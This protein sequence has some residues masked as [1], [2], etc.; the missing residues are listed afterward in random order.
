MVL[1]PAILLM[2]FFFPGVSLAQ[3]GGT[4]EKAALRDIIK[5]RWEKAEAR[6][7][8]S[9]ARDSLNPSARY[10][11]SLYYFHNDNPAYH[12]D[13]AYRY[14]VTAI[15][16]YLSV[17]AKTRDRLKRSDL[18]STAVATLRV[19]IETAAFEVARS[20][21]TEPAYVSFLRHFPS[22][23]QRQVAE[24]LRNEVAYQTALRENTTDAFRRYFVS[25]PHSKRA[26]DAQ[27]RYDRMLF[28]EATTDRQ[29]ASY[30][31]FL[32]AHP[33]TPYKEEIHKTIFE[34]STARGNAESYLSFI[35]DYPSNQF[36]ERAR[37]IVFYLLAED[38]QPDW[39]EGFLTDSLRNILTL[40]AQGLVP[41]LKDDRF[42][43]MNYQGVEII[44]PTYE[45]IHEDYLCG[46]V[47]DDILIVDNRLVTRDGITICRE[48]VS[49]LTDLGAGFLLVFSGGKTSVLHKSGFIVTDS[50]DD[51]RVINKRFLAVR[52]RDAWWLY[53]LTGRLL[54]ARPW[55]NIDAVHDL[56]LLTQK[57]KKFIGRLGEMSGNIEATALS[58]SDAF[59]EVK[60]W[61][62]GLIWGRSGNFEGVLNDRLESVIRFDR[63]GLNRTSFGATATLQSGFALYNHA[64]KR[65]SIFE[66]VKVLGKRVAVRKNGSWVFFDPLTHTTIGRTYDSLRFE[67]P[68]FLV[69]GDSVTAHFQN[70]SA[71]RFFRPRAI[72]FVPGMDSTSFLVVDANGREK[73]IFDANGN[74]LFA[75]SFDAIEYAGRGIFVISRREKKGLIT[76]KGQRLLPPEF[77]AVGSVQDGIISV[78]KNKKFGTFNI[79]KRKLIQPIYDRNP[80]PYM[81]EI[82]TVFKDGYYGFVGWDGNP[83]SPFEFDEVAPW[84]D[85]V[86]LVRQ[87]SSWS[88]YQ[89]ATGRILETGLRSI[90]VVSDGPNEKV[91]IVQKGNDFGVLSN[92]GKEIIPIT[93]SDIINIGS[94]QSPL[95]FTEKHIPEASLHV[96]IYFDAA[97]N[98][99]RKEMYDDAFNF[100]RI[101]CSDH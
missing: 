49:A 95:Y 7:R 37:Q 34:L 81:Q 5:H 85:S 76:D 60:P 25:Y 84:S 98:M 24:E 31:A 33:E 86:A 62:N 27:M 19:R 74:K 20:E 11:L 12:L 21:N 83:L 67:G 17:S 89:I 77:D 80:V 16:D 44:P 50:V 59:D 2:I 69:V 94:R 38:D 71:R 51:A 22:A 47:N 52:E 79:E 8:K 70:G 91:A 92:T 40:N 3:A 26:G 14:A 57:D 46:N 42:G 64:G 53:T 65:S 41:F 30:E 28:E 10:A 23:M 97:G 99:I 39:P 55:H 72:S 88:L 35:R 73:A 18:D 96:V 87:G 100:D 43:F 4:P 75:S 63:H 56:L 45:Q 93:F 6:L 58:V 15:D 61:P 29:L 90:S 82:M 32:K 78:L 9:L 1:R 66:Q 68:F 36:V 48:P 13:S 54:D 101:Y